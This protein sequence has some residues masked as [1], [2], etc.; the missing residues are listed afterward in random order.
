MT[1]D[2]TKRHGIYYTATAVAEA[3]TGWA[4]RHDGVK[5]LDPSFGGGVFLG[6][7]VGALSRLGGSARTVYGVERDGASVAGVRREMGHRFHLPADNLL[8]GDFLGLP[9]RKFPEI[10]VVVG[11]PPFVRYQ[12]L[13][14]AERR[15]AHERSL[16]LGVHLSGRANVW[17]AFVVQ[18]LALLA[19]RG[20]LAMI[21]PT[22]LVH[23]R[24]ARPVLEALSR[25]FAHCTLV[26]FQR[27]LFPS[28]DQATLI[29]LA[30]DKGRSCSNFSLLE[31]DNPRQLTAATLRQHREHPRRHAQRIDAARLQ[32]GDFAFGSH[33][34]GRSARHLYRALQDSDAV[35]TLGRLARVATGYVTGANAFFHLKPADVER[36]RLPDS[37][38][39]PAIFRSRALAGLILGE[40]DWR[41][42]TSMASA[43]HLFASEERPTKAVSAYLRYG[44]QSGVPRGY[45]TRHRKPWYRVPGAT[46]PDLLLTPMSHHHPRLSRN[47]ARVV[48][49][50]T[51]QGVFLSR[52]TEG[53]TAELGDR[54]CIS[55]LTSLTTLSAELEGHALGGGM[56]KLEPV[57][58]RRLLIP[59]PT[60]IPAGLLKRLDA[61]VRSG[62]RG[63]ALA[64]ADELVLREGLGLS[65]KD[66]RLLRAAAGWLATRRKDSG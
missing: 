12:L 7:A 36:W 64:I 24:Y 3:M 56:L 11:N 31:L 41:Q 4:I 2:L 10:D 65:A 62:H 35:T 55:W 28:L 58:T 29:L 45:K 61:L 51:F 59:L 23:A 19:Q 13:E 8:H 54:I 49:P 15:R 5:V 40:D 66:C 44:E 27:P 57:A 18:S 33:L 37:C 14:E 9:L 6:A 21:L 47:D 46:P 16:E 32:S 30:E 48:V 60:P 52:E 34:I 63:E 39:K 1:E 26:T 53:K 20:R 50:N 17:A 25:S 42:A 38:L 43:G 22:S